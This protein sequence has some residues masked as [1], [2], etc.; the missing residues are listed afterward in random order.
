MAPESPGISWE[1]YDA[2]LNVEDFTKGF[3]G[4]AD[5]RAPLFPHKRKYD[6]I[7]C[8]EVAEH[9]H[10]AFEYQVMRNIV[11][12]AKCGVV[13]SWAL[14]DEPGFHHVN[15]RDNKYIRTKMAELGFVYNSELS[16][17]RFRAQ[18]AWFHKT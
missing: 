11:T 3:V 4:W 1:G 18:Y 9:V 2:A 13:L 8:L 7:L 5:L 15:T 17:L 6:W 16:K 10:H 14:P 12:Y